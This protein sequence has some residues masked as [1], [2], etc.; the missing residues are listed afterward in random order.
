MFAVNEVAAEAI[1]RAYAEGGEL[2][3]VAELRRHFPLVAD[4][5]DVREFVQIIASW[6][7]IQTPVSRRLPP[8][9]RN[10]PSPSLP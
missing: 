9:R 10:K 3:G 4:S 8:I 2:S 6:K 7:P 5:P 1:R